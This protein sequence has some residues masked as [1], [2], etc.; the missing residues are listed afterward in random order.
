MLKTYRRCKIVLLKFKDKTTNEVYQYF[1]H[2][3]SYNSK[4]YFKNLSRAEP[5]FTTY[6][7]KKELREKIFKTK[8]KLKYT[9][10]IYER[11]RKIKL[12]EKDLIITLTDE[13]ETILKKMLKR[14]PH[15]CDDCIY[16]NTYLLTG[17]CDKTFEKNII[18]EKMQ[19]KSNTF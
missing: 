9:I 2:H 16:R 10:E 12:V 3:T 15:L 1:L 19:I 5:K 14:I 6:L 17:K 11:S 13:T 4:V 18:N 8:E 7:I